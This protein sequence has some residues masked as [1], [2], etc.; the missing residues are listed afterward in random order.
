MSSAAPSPKPPSARGIRTRQRLLDAAICVIAESGLEGFSHRTVAKEAGL[1]LALTTYYFADKAE[2]LAEAFRHFGTRGEPGLQALW[3]A[4][5][6]IVAR[7]K[8]DLDRDAG[9][10]ALTT[11]ATD[12]ICLAERPALDGIAFELA[13]FYAR[14][15][16][17][18]LE[19]EVRRYRA[20][21]V[22]AS[23]DLCMQAGSP[24]PETDAELLVGTI[25]RLEFEQLSAAAPA[26]RERV[27]AQLRRLLD[28]MIA[29]EGLPETQPATP[30]QAKP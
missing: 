30:P 21:L 9:L 29:P 6:D 16:E 10:D 26:R 23:R 24:E 17:P 8:T 1:A 15:L 20:R 18:A 13:F 2:L 12:Y 14:S 27:A 5:Q 7:M 3:S 25:L 28:P 19:D 22:A 4:A 11:L